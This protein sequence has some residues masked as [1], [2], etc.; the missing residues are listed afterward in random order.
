VS[1]PDVR[2]EGGDLPRTGDETVDAAVERLLD[3]APDTPP[4][5]QLPVLA[6]VHEA[7]QQ[8]LAA[9]AE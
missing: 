9:A 3:L 6:G 1:E 5:E 2:P 8:R 7:L 4:A